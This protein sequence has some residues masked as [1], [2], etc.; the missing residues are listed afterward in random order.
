MASVNEITII[1][2][3][4]RDVEMRYTSNGNPVA[5]FTVAVDRPT[6]EKST[7]FVPIVAWQRTAELAN[8]F[9]AKGSLVYV[10]GR[11]QIRKYEH[12]GQKR[13]AAEVVADRLQFLERR[14]DDGGE[15]Q[16]SS[17]EGGRSSSAGYGDGGGGGFPPHDDSLGIDD[18]PFQAC[19]V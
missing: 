2:R 19:K 17:R 12:D 6:K 4:T 9:L 10:K 3:L 8:E 15:R 11:L 18:I 7:D 1:G 14:K 5:N 13:E 16:P